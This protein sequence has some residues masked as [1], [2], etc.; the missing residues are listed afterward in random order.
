[1]SLLYS[2]LKKLV[3]LIAVVLMASCQFAPVMAQNVRTYIHPRI[4]PLVPVYR[5]ELA[6]HFPQIP[7]PWYVLGLTEHES[8]ISLKHSRCWSATS[9]FATKWKETNTPRELGV[10]LAMITKAWT[11]EGNVRMDTLSNLKK[12]YPTELRDLTWDNISQRPDLQIRAMVLLLRSDYRGLSSVKDPVERLKMT[13]SA[14]NGGR[15]DVERARKVC[16]LTKGCNPEIWFGHVE[17]HSPK[18]TKVLYGDRSAKDINLHHVH[19][20]FDVRM[21]KFKPIL[22]TI[23]KQ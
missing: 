4:A 10:G 14:Y 5:Q 7:Q 11:K 22:P 17:K 19:D 21:P 8:C 15:R 20:V 16:G 13:D 23:E 3:W 18:S 9:Q 6:A 1:M 2:H 12:V